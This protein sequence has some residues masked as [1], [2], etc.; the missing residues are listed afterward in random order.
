M[1]LKGWRKRLGLKIEK[2][3]NLGISICQT[4]KCQKVSRKTS[5]YFGILLCKKSVSYYTKN[6]TIKNK[7]LQGQET[8]SVKN[9]KKSKVGK[10]M[11]ENS[12]FFFRKTFDQEFLMTTFSLLG[13]N[14]LPTRARKILGYKINV[15]FFIDQRFVYLLVTSNTT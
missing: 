9:R 7:G 4:S 15:F 14:M 5:E 8:F 6:K 1:W 2:N 13:Q 10:K 11:N 3:R 12:E